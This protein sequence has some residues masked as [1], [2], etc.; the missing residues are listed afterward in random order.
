MGIDVHQPLECGI[1]LIKTGLSSDP[2]LNSL[3]FSGVNGNPHNIHQLKTFV[4]F[5]KQKGSGRL[6]TAE[7]DPSQPLSSGILSPA[8]DRPQCPPD[9]ER[10]SLAQWES[11]SCLT[12]ASR[13]SCSDPRKN[14]TPWFGG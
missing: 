5:F 14:W 13:G 6:G 10:A 8:P 7:K 3:T 11:S 12:G 4:V 2:L 9:T 1:L